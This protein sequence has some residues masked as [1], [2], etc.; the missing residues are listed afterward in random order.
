MQMRWDG[1]TKD[2]YDSLRSIVNWEG[3]KPNG[4]VFHAAA[5]DDAGGHVTDIWESGEEFNNFVQ[6]RL[7]PGVA[8][9]GVTTQPHVEVYPLHAIYNPGL[10]KTV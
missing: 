8:Q 10:D 2:Q 3:D 4:A 1:F 6:S 9:I 5:F 7:M